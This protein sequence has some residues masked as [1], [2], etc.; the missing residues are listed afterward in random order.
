MTVNF[1]SF[2][3][4][5]NHVTNRQ[6]K[7]NNQQPS[8]GI[9]KELRE[10][11][12][13]VRKAT[14][15]YGHNNLD[16]LPEKYFKQL[17]KGTVFES[18]SKEN[19]SRFFEIDLLPL[20]RGCKNGCGHCMVKAVPFK[21]KPGVINSMSW[22][23]F[24][25]LTLSL[26][27][28][29]V[30]TNNAI[31]FRFKRK[32]IY[33]YFNNGPIPSNMLDEK[34]HVH[35][36][37][38]AGKR[39]YKRTGI[40]FH[41]TNAGWDLT[42]IEAQKAAEELRNTILKNPNTFDNVDVS[43]HPF[44]NYMMQS[45]NYAKHGKTTESRALREKYVNRTANSLKTFLPLDNKGK[46]Y[47]NLLHAPEL[48]KNTGYRKSETLA[49]LNEIS[50][51]LYELVQKENNPLYSEFKSLTKDQLSEKITEI[52]GNSN[53]LQPWGRA[54]RFFKEGTLPND[55]IYNGLD[56]NGELFEY[57]NE[58]KFKHLGIFLNFENKNK[59]PINCEKACN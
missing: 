11:V 45:I 34:G 10:A 50:D 14:K 57:S 16:M 20:M 18:F 5:Q 47:I 40:P 48:E 58:K 56:V 54:K 59:K 41:I 31:N 2:N 32:A 38:Q 13:A 46:L 23:D 53:T 30:R 1:L 19:L 17:L 15:D 42:E 49:L 9:T 25:A 44:H 21:E 43:I 6:N 3:T 24:S 35:N 29:R 22:E 8:F 52:S 36:I 12:L 27:K 7:P 51:K 33:P 4:V 28:I 39:F 37:V 55:F 26:E